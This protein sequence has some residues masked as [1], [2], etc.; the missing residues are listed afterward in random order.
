MDN[1][2]S[3]K[4]EKHISFVRK[5]MDTLYLQNT[6]E[7]IPNYSANAIEK[8]I[9]KYKVIS[10][11]I[12]D[13]SVRRKVPEPEDIFELVARAS[14][15]KD[16]NE[17][18]YFRKLAR[19]SARE[20]AYRN[21]LEEVTLNEIYKTLPD[22]YQDKISE[23]INYEERIE[24]E[25]CFADPVIY[26]VYKWCVDNNKIVIFT[27][28]MYLSKNV[29]EYILK[30]CGYT[31]YNNLFISSETKKTKRTGSLFEYIVRNYYQTSKIVHIGDNIKS[32]YLI[33]QR[34][35][36]KS[37]KTA[38]YPKRTIF[39]RQKHWKDE[40][41]G[42]FYNDLCKLLNYG[43]NL[44]GDYYW[45]YGYECLG[46]LLFGTAV[47]LNKIIEDGRFDHIFFLARD[48][49]LIKKIFDLLYPQYSN[50]ETYL[51]ISRKAIQY[52]LLV[53]Y[54]NI[55]DY[56]LLN[57]V[58]KKW[59]FTMFCNRVGIDSS[60]AASVWKKCGL[61]L[62]YMFYAKDIVQDSRIQKFY[63]QY[64][65]QIRT[66]SSKK[67]KIVKQYLLENSFKGNVLIVDTGGYATTQ[68]CLERFCAN[69][70]I[71]VQITG[72]YLWTFD[73]PGFKVFTYPFKDTT[74]HGGE[75]QLTELPLTAHE[76]TTEG[77]YSNQDG[78][79]LPYLAEYEYKDSQEMEKAINSIQAGAVAFTSQFS[80]YKELDRLTK[81]VV[82]A[83]TKYVSRYPRLLDA[84]KFGSL[85]FM[86]DHQ[87]NYLARP[88]TLQYYLLHLHELKRDFTHANWK[89]GFLKLLFKVP[90]PY[91][92][93]IMYS[94]NVIEKIK[95]KR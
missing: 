38:K 58:R 73:N 49:Y 7:K 3:H 35:G 76:G 20:N 5:F 4:E 65:K 2:L 1:K 34:F 36:I 86:S 25:C 56:L 68:K 55:S 89:I 37:V 17:F 79:I 67:K 81:D 29:V 78:K 31:K 83:N 62:D 75:T 50:K 72:A 22:K 16:I 42:F 85:S 87:K 77:Y 24:I 70:G 63:A 92:S 82:Y 27:S 69:N 9:Q 26:E 41:D 90:L 93:I 11:D 80:I 8:K 53:D 18:V 23:L 6:I 64:E 39:C 61:N 30:K 71:S 51:Y 52:P 19:T 15:I 74:S 54:D 45:K 43:N 32:D 88:K 40:K 21:G 46:P 66:E 48:G 91:Y 47:N 14:G 10:F 28:D 59:N 84:K 95:A 57:G 13:T 33:P 44:D 94:R 60:K 12:F